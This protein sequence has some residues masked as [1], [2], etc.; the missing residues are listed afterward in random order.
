MPKYIEKAEKCRLPVIVLRGLIAFPSIPVS[1]ELTD[2][3]LISAC[4]D[5]EN[6][7]GLIFVVSLK[8]LTLDEKNSDNFFKVGTAAQIKQTVKLPDGTLKVF[9][10]G[11]CRASAERYDENEGKFYADLICKTISAEGNGGIKGEALA[12]EI[13]KSFDAFS[14]YLPKVSNELVTAVKSIK[15][16]GLLADFIACNVLMNYNDKQAVLEEFNPFRRAELVSFL[17]ER[18]SEILKA[19]LKESHFRS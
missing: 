6:E 14:G 5:A 8:D 16:F 15:N 13:K 18:E 11:Y 3:A 7:N 12:L 10:T 19:E 2:E 4:I 9:V 17:M 1:F